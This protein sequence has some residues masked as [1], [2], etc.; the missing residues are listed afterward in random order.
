MTSHDPTCIFCK[1]AA[2]GI[3]AQRLY[4]DDDVLAFHDIRPAAPLHFLLIPKQHVASL[5]E[6]NEAHQPLLGKLLALAPSLV[7]KQGFDDGFRTVINTGP[8][9]GQEV[10]HLHLHVMAG[11]RPWKNG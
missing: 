1:I 8:N 4:E 9:G 10:D 5:A 6:A 2:G 7:R 3:P 11:P